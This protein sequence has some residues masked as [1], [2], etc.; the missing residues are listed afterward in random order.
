MAGT[1]RGNM[2]PLRGNNSRVVGILC[3]DIHLCGKPPIARSGEPDWYKAMVRPL[4]EV[5]ALAETHHAPVLCAGDVFDHWRSEPELINFALNEL[6][7]MWAIP[8]QHDLPQHSME[9]IH[10]SAFQT[11][12]QAGVIHIPD[13]AGTEISDDVVVYPFPWGVPLTFPH[14]NSSVG[15]LDVA[16]LHEYVWT[17]GTE[18][19]GGAAPKSGEV[20]SL[21]IRAKG[22]DVVVSGDNHIPFDVVEAGTLIWNCG[23]F[24]RRKITEVNATPRVGLLHAD[25][26]VTPHYLDIAGEVLEDH[27]PVTVTCPAVPDFG[28]FVEGWKLLGV[29]EFDFPAAVEKAMREQETPE[30]TRK[31]V[32][33]A[34]GK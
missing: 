13:P 30:N 10:R 9:L 20:S 6:P 34:L 29:D 22:F 28:E 11:L 4:R 15:K 27:G 19:G 8:G 25:G 14:R 12:V 33:L 32:L 1:G 3:A 5:K 18:F 7:E 17:P 31:I 16:L 23:G 2:P 21:M 24:M 26:T